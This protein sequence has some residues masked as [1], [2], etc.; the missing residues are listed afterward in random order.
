MGV[1]GHK[2]ALL[3]LRNIALYRT[4]RFNDM[5]RITPGLTRR[6][7]SMRLR[8][9][10]RDGLIEVVE[11]GQNYLK[12]GLTEKGNDALPVLLSL[13]GF[14]SKWYAEKVFSDKAPRPLM[15]VFDESY[16][17]KVLESL[18]EEETLSPRLRVNGPDRLE[19]AYGH[20]IPRSNKP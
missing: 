13:V 15:D 10:E 3:V 2:W 5:L 14:G 7:L 8:E 9:L 20:R 17:R 1:L 12:W 6:V 11:K 19:G 16:V 18:T 4:Q